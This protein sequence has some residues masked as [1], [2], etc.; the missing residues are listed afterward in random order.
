MGIEHSC[1]ICGHALRRVCA[2]LDPVYQ[3]PIAVCPSCAAPCVRRRHPLA[4]WWRG[5]HR[6]RAAI[7]GLGW[8]ALAGILMVAI[9]IGVC[10]T[11][12]ES[13][14]NL[15]PLQLAQRMREGTID[16]DWIESWK[17]GN[18]PLIVGVSAGWCIA[19]GATLTAG[20]AHVRRRW[21][22]WALMV[23]AV[24]GVLLVNAAQSWAMGA[25]YHPSSGGRVVAMTA[26]LAAFRRLSGW[27]AM[28]L[29]LA[30]LGIPV[31][32]ALRGTL[33]KRDAR[34]WIKKLARSR[35]RRLAI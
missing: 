5:F 6:A 31:G 20:L 8:R 7:I 9:T 15:G 33:A 10:S 19:V 4:V 11:L 18:G 26:H 25:A 24:A 32:L 30:P 28:G 13:L 22:L 29:A 23:C 21:T 35:R 27:L 2:T 16:A 14:H 3:L 1:H 34:R 12:G 17:Q